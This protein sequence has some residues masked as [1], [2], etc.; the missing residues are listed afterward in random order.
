MSSLTVPND[1]LATANLPAILLQFMALALDCRTGEIETVLRSSGLR[2]KDGLCW[3]YRLLFAVNAVG[4]TEHRLGGDRL[5]NYVPLPLDSAEPIMLADCY[6]A[7]VEIHFYGSTWQIELQ[8]PKNLGGRHDRL[9][10]MLR[11]GSDPR[12]TSYLRRLPTHW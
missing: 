11:C 4:R 10:D 8:S 2:S 6:G 1:S 3:P 12:V 5:I 7:V 9:P